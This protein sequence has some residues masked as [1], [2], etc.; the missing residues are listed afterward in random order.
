MYLQVHESIDPFIKLTTPNSN[1]HYQRRMGDAVELVVNVDAY[2]STE[3]KWVD[4][5]GNEIP[6]ILWLHG[7]LKLS[8]NNACC[9]PTL[10]INSLDLNDMGI[11]S[12]QA[13]NRYK[14]EALN[15]TLEIVAEPKVYMNISSSNY[16]KNQVAKAECYVE[17]FPKPNITWSYRKC[18]NY[19]SCDDGTLE[20]VTNSR[21]N[22]NVTHLLSTLSATLDMYGEVICRACNI[23]G[24]GNVTENVYV[25]DEVGEFGVILVK[26][27]VIEGDDWELICAASVRTYSDNFDWSSESGPIVQS[28]SFNI[29]AKFALNNLLVYN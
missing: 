26:H 17:A 2:P 1:R 6:T 5:R 11:Y 12:I 10:K 14:K 19:P 27:L 29:H 4:A 24:C 7:R 28:G 25:S 18:P 16:F 13:S 15:F 9:K 3:L 23:V 20:H 8:A 21:E 22:G